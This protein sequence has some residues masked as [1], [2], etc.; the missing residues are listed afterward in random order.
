MRGK[1]DD[2]ITKCCDV[3]N[4]QLN[5][6]SKSFRWCISTEPENFPR[7]TQPLSVFLRTYP[8][9]WTIEEKESYLMNIV[10]GGHMPWHGVKSR[11]RDSE[12]DWPRNNDGYVIPELSKIIELGGK[13]VKN[14][15]DKFD[16]YRFNYIHQC[17]NCYKHFSELPVEN[18]GDLGGSPQGL[19]AKMEEWDPNIWTKLYHIFGPLVR[20]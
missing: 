6:L 20:M 14:T 18:Q 10:S 16:Y 17:R 19:I 13:W 4:V 15:D 2:I 1:L 3:N 5:H 12:I 9:V 11:I 8:D 7:I